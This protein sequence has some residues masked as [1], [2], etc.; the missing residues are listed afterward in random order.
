MCFQV[1]NSAKSLTIF[2][3]AYFVVAVCAD[4]VDLKKRP[5]KDG[6]A[7]TIIEIATVTCGWLAALGYAL[8]LLIFTDSDAAVEHGQCRLF[9]PAGRLDSMQK[10]TSTYG[11]INIFGSDVW[12]PAYAA[13]EESEIP[14]ES[15][16]PECK[17]PNNLAYFAWIYISFVTVF[18]F[19]ALIC[20]ILFILNKF[21][22]SKRA[23][24]VTS[25][26]PE[27]SSRARKPP[28][29]AKSPF[30][31]CQPA[32]CWV[33]ALCAAHF[34]SWLPLHVYHLGR[35]VGLRVGLTAC[36]NLR[37]YS[38][39]QGYLTCIFL[40][41]IVIAYSRPLGARSCSRTLTTSSTSSF[42]SS[43]SGGSNRKS[44][45]L[46][47]NGENLLGD[48]P[49]DVPLIEQQATHISQQREEPTLLS[50]LQRSSK[51]SV[52]RV[53]CSNAAS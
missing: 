15:S 4:Y 39:L 51:S 23:M 44:M 53:A 1:A 52:W 9:A 38:F 26:P 22:P 41:A 45:L 29:T 36:Y 10:D 46:Q 21:L 37:D 25:S 49:C 7:R 43:S 19:P 13:K 28:G 20:F 50:N 33:F 12:S 18:A 2:T 40:P 3:Q 11:E 16:L 5:R 34:A 6:L 31:R 14:P 27:T 30:R 42:A 35:I 17:E 47:A 32:G 24:L 8:P 48:G